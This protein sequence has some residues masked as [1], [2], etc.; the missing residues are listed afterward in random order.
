MPGSVCILLDS[1]LPAVYVAAVSWECRRIFCLPR[2]TTSHQYKTRFIGS[3]KTA[4]ILFLVRHSLISTRASFIQVSK[5]LLSMA[6]DSVSQTISCY[7]PYQG[8]SRPGR[9][10]R[11][12]MTAV[13]GRLYH[14]TMYCTACTVHVTNDV[15]QRCGQRVATVSVGGGGGL[16]DYLPQIFS[17][18]PHKSCTLLFAPIMA[19][20]DSST[21]RGL[22][23]GDRHVW[24]GLDPP[25]QLGPSNSLRNVSRLH[26]P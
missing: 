25:Q 12:R 4:A 19:V 9:A 24:H 21:P 23:A 11:Q 10:R 15:Q 20:C 14:K 26:S 6:R 16:P 17:V 2:A 8:S 1:W 3:I 22:V 7:R 18:L 13:I 5:H